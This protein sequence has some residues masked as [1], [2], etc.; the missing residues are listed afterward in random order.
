M[1]L[2]PNPLRPKLIR[3]SFRGVPPA[4]VAIVLF[5]IFVI[6]NTTR[7]SGGPANERQ[8]YQRGNKSTRSAV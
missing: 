1:S 7:P 4:A 8:F 2:R 5:I 6:V 3:S